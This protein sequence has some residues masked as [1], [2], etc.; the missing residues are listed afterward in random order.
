MSAPRVR[1]LG[2]SAMLVHLHDEIGDVAHHAVMAAFH[3]LRAAPPA[4]CTDVVPAYTGVAVHYDVTRVPG[5]DP[6]TAV[7]AWLAQVAGNAE[8]GESTAPRVIAIPVRYGGEFGPDLEDVA[9]HA[10]LTADEV[11]ARHTDGSY[12]VHM[13]GFAPGFAYLAGLDAALHM[14]RLSTPR[15]RV[16]AGSV[17]IA[18][19]QTGVYP[20]ATPG[21]WRLIGRTDL[22]LFDPAA[23]PPTLLQPGD[24]VR[25]R[26]L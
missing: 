16:P 1:P 14:P 19:A 24:R 3:A 21:G 8:A 15:T 26:A 11:V 22:R 2:D 18:G 17:G 20:L 25:F 7:A 6:A 9:A 10:G 4:W 23:D 12:T 5:D 13:M